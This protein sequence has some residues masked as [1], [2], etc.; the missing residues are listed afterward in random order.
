MLPETKLLRDEFTQKLNVLK[1]CCCNGAK[2]IT[3]E[4][5]LILISQSKVR[6]GVLY[7]IT[8]VHKN[9]VGVTIPVL[10][11]DGTNSG[12]T[13]YVWGITK[14]EFSTEG[15]GEFYNPKY[16]QISYGF[17]DL[18]I[19]QPLVID[20]G[21][22]G[23]VD[24]P[25]GEY[26]TGGTGGGI[27]I[28]WLTTAGV[29]TSAWIVDPGAGYANGDELNPS[30]GDNNASLF[31]EGLLYMYN[32]YDGNNP[33]APIPAFT[34]VGTKIIWGGYVW[35]SLTGNIS[36]AISPVELNSDDWGKIQ[37][38]T[39]DYDLV[40]DYIEYD[41]PNDWILRR[42]QAEPVIDVIFPYQYW[43][44][45]ENTYGV[46]LHGIS[47]MQW[48]NNYKAA[49][50]HGIGLI[51]VKD[52]YAELI[53]FKGKL[54]L[55]LTLNEYS[56]KRAEYY[57]INTEFKT[58]NVKG[59]SYQTNN[60]YD[61]GGKQIDHLMEAQSW[62]DLIVIKNN[63]QQV[64]MQ[65][66]NGSWQNG[67]ENHMI[68]DNS[69]IQDG[70]TLMNGSYQQNIMDN[71]QEIAATYVNGAYSSFN[72]IDTVLRYWYVDATVVSHNLTQCI[73]NNLIFKNGLSINAV[74]TNTIEQYS[75]YGNTSNEFNFKILFNG[76]AGRG[77]V[78]AITI[79][80]YM[81]NLSEMYIEEVIITSKNLVGGVGSY[82]TLGIVT[83]DDDSGLTAVTGLVTTIN[84]TTQKYTNLP[85]TKSAAADRYLVMAVG[86]NDI[87]GGTVVL[88]VKTRYGNFT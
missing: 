50:E 43:N 9:K 13:I 10:Y 61:T 72:L 76:T 62:Q 33:N 68:L 21:G 65:I 64:K 17:L 22:T 38:N 36:S 67:S 79:P 46:V 19:G 69:S 85:F 78:G 82:I 77:V 23:Y 4:E 56:V 44:S 7:R 29:I 24:N 86:A 28:G 47:V 11:D 73:K 20:N 66:I 81:L 51:E 42:R 59:K 25:D 41:W 75:I 74:D 6:S 37:Y 8:G 15:W 48:G 53:N 60:I 26:V 71:S 27:S 32:I 39:T 54:L 12:T 70:V 55:G 84:N 3:Y 88:N 35:E 58:I 18:R 31:I 45:V 63:S 80:I 1:N 5:A 30:S 14:T 16:D 57:G 52:A 40:I 87:T 83:D 34:A 2:T 49:T